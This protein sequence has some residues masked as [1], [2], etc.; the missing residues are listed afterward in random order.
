MVENEIKFY[1]GKLGITPEYLSRIVRR[2]TGKTVMHFL[3]RM[4]IT[5]ASRQLIHSDV[6]MTELASYLNFATSAGLSKF[7]KHHK[8]ISPL[9]YRQLHKRM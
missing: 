6:S 3:D 4:L 2:I 1:S 5:G 7:F 9:K 8:G